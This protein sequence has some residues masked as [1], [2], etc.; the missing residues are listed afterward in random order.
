MLEHYWGGF[1]EEIGLELGFEGQVLLCLCWGQGK[2]GE[3]T[4]LAEEI[5]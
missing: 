3:W 4:L 2:G 1:L 5:T